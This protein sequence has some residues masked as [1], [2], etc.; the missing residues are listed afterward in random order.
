M[1]HW[2]VDKQING[3]R[4]FQRTTD[5]MPRSAHIYPIC[6]VEW[7]SYDTVDLK[8]YVLEDGHAF[9]AVVFFGETPPP[10]K[11]SKILRG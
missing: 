3:Q 7:H 6:T 10:P 9:F 5:S 1:V 4:S 2:F 11:K 8:L